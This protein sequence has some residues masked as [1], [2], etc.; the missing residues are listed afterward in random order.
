MLYKVMKATL[1]ALAAV[2][3]VLPAALTAQTPT[4]D[5]SANSKKIT[6]TKRYLDKDGNEMSEILVK[7]GAAAE[8]FDVDQYLRDNEKS[9]T[10]L[11]IRIE[12]NDEERIVRRSSTKGRS[13]GDNRY[14]MRRD[15]DN[16]VNIST[17]ERGFLGVEEDDDE[18]EDT[19]GLVVDVIEGTAAEMAGLQDNDVILSLNGRPTDR[20]S[21]LSRFMQGSRSGDEVR[22]VYRRDGKEKQATAV[23]RSKTDRTYSQKRR[24]RGYLG[25]NLRSGDDQRVGVEVKVLP[26]S[27]AAK[28]GLRTGDVVVAL[29]STTIRDWE[30]ITDFMSQTSVNDTI[31][32]TYRRNDEERRIPVVL[33]AETSWYW[34]ISS[35]D[36]KDLN[37]NIRNK[38][39]CIGVYSENE[40]EGDEEGARITDFTDK[41][42]ARESNLRVGDV[43]VGVNGQRVR[44]ENS[45][46][47]EIAKYKPGERVSVKFLRD[48]KFQTM[49]VVLRPCQDKSRV[50][51]SNT[52]SLGNNRSRDFFTWNWDR[53][54]EDRMRKKQV[55]TIQKG[56]EGDGAKMSA[57]DRNGLKEMKLDSYR[58][59]RD[60]KT[61]IV[62]ISFKAESIPTVVSLYDADGRQL[63]REELNAFSGDY[64]QQFDLSA[65]AS[66]TVLVEVRQADLVF[67]ERLVM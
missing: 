10:D 31:T 17:D 3:L 37:F 29:N 52:D 1:T 6:I 2:L 46:W 36:L 43:I 41:S 56:E 54:A 28:A 47:S 49:D 45:L 20:W 35:D 34:G 62:D 21:D 32:V 66:N 59:D 12:Q 13:Q 33:A 67:V 25:I 19:Q 55:I 48:G 7:K 50:T 61:G 9:D 24:S 16:T 8:A 64:R 58:A 40:G 26:N 53:S 30:D 23:L 38:D 51:F 15:N 4:P 11:E 63:F 57:A 18:D 27:V 22:I 39:A 14:D 5:N 60:A 44:G 42:P 65:F